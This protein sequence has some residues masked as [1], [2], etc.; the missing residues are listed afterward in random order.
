MCFHIHLIH[1]LRIPEALLPLAPTYSRPVTCVIHQAFDSTSCVS[2]VPNFRSEHGYV[3]CLALQ[4]VTEFH[5]AIVCSLGNS[6]ASSVFNDDSYRKV[7]TATVQHYVRRRRYSTRSGKQRAPP[8]GPVISLRSIIS[9]PRAIQ[10]IL[11]SFNRPIRHAV[12]SA[13]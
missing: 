8:V 12:I 2:D 9:V 10:V 13:N 4:T 7:R 6:L 11:R 5:V 1:K 3:A